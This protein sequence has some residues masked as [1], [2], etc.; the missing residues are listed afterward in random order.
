VRGGGAYDSMPD[1]SAAKL[2]M[3]A[4]A[5][6]KVVAVGTALVPEDSSRPLHGS[7]RAGLPHRA[8][9]VGTSVKAMTRPSMKDLCPG[10]PAGC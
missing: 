4:V 9:A 7:R 6:G 2:A 8:L 10:E 1:N 3:R 5:L